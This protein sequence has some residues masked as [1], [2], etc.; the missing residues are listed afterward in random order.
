MNEMNNV[1]VDWLSI[2]IPIILSSSSCEQQ[3]LKYAND[4]FKNYI[5]K[6]LNL[7]KEE[8]DWTPYN[9]SSYRHKGII[10]FGQYMKFGLCSLD[11]KRISYE[12]YKKWFD[13]ED[14]FYKDLNKDIDGSTEFYYMSLIFSGQACREF[15]ERFDLTWTEWLDYLINGFHAW[16]TRVDLAC[17]LINYKSFKFSTVV[18]FAKRQWYTSIF[19]TVSKIYDD[20]DGQGIYFGQSKG[21]NC[22]LFYNK[23][24]ERMKANY[25]IS[26][27]VESWLRIEQRFYTNAK[28][29]AELLA[30]TPFENYNKIY[31]QILYNNLDFKKVNANESSLRGENLDRC[32]TIFWWKK[33]FKDIEKLKVKNQHRLE[34]TLTTTRKWIEKEIPVG[35]AKL[36]CVEENVVYD[37]AYTNEIKIKGLEKLME[38]P[39]ELSKVNN[40]RLLMG[41]PILTKIDIM[42]LI[43]D[44]KVLDSY[45]TGEVIE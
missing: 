22:I 44:V 32:E 26:E 4:F 15:E 37:F 19:K 1:C 40:Q 34:S 6:K 31:L 30:K 13:A 42:K 33:L 2:N 38:N 11:T 17:D 36:C 20:G 21:S 29:V 10:K 45:V 25:N 14:S 8:I 12:E 18:D 28:E 39:K 24:L 23:M 3:R 27:G 7:L 9:G 5:V 43:K 35:V 41:K 16:A